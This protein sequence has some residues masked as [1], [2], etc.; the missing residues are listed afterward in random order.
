MVPAAMSRSHRE[1]EPNVS[2][3]RTK[4]SRAGGAALVSALAGMFV[5]VGAPSA[6]QS[7]GGG[8]AVMFDAT[9]D[10]GHVFVDW[11]RI[12]PPY[13][14]VFTD[15][16]L[17][18]NDILVVDGRQVCGLG[19]I[20]RMIDAGERTPDVLANYLLEL[21]STMLRDG[22]S[23]G[24]TWARVEATADALVP[25]EVVELRRERCIGIQTGGLQVRRG[26]FERI[27]AGVMVVMVPLDDEPQR[28]V[29]FAQLFRS[30]A[31][32]LFTVLSHGGLLHFDR[33]CGWPD[34]RVGSD[35][36][37]AAA[38]LEVMRRLHRGHLG[39]RARDGIASRH[40]VQTELLRGYAGWL[41]HS[42]DSPREGDFYRDPC[43]TARGPR[44]L[45]TVG[46]DTRPP[47][48][49]APASRWKQDRP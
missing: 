22:W 7:V 43:A 6:Q 34:V 31:E 9:T 8:G 27:R 21:R 20:R 44:A 40:G 13:R 16:T 19:R 18:V 37:E 47:R 24:E 14:V 17:R 2:I 35:T 29:A 49:V 46:P 15:S 38:M 33:Y 48:R 23:L 10:S 39:P 1:S 42:L 3:S 36:R 28:H 30:D 41:R 32:W 5:A 4:W 11:E 26:R 45:R 12:P 25:P